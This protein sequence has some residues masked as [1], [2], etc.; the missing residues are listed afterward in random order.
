[1]VGAADAMLKAA[2]VQLTAHEIIGA[3]LCTAIIRGS[4]TNVA[5]GSRNA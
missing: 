2:D 3:G 1:M 4:V 5:T